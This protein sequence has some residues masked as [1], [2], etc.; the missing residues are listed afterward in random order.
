MSWKQF[1]VL[2]PYETAVVERLGRY[3]PGLK[4]NNFWKIPFLDRVITFDMR[5]QRI[6]VGF[7]GN[8]GMNKESYKNWLEKAILTS[9]MERYGESSGKSKF[10]AIRNEAL[11][12]AHSVVRNQIVVDRQLFDRVME[13][14]G[15]KI[16]RSQ[17]PQI[18]DAIDKIAIYSRGRNPIAMKIAALS[19]SELQDLKELIYA[20]TDLDTSVTSGETVLMELTAAELKAKIDTMTINT[21]NRIAYIQFLEDEYLKVM[22]EASDLKFRRVGSLFT[23]DRILINIGAT[24]LFRIEDPFRTIELIGVHDYKRT[25]IG[26]LVSSL[27]A[28][29]A[30]LTLK[31]MFEER[32]KL[33][34]LLR[35]ELD[36]V[37]VKWGIDVLSVSIEEIF[38]D[39]IKL[40]SILDDIRQEQL[41]GQTQMKRAQAELNTKRVE[42]DTKFE[43]E[44][45][46]KEAEV[47]GMIASA[48]RKLE[49]KKIEIE[50]QLTN[51]ENRF[52][53]EKTSI[54]ARKN[55]V[56][57]QIEGLIRLKNSINDDV[58]KY[59][60]MEKLPRIINDVIT[61]SK[62]IVASPG[63]DHNSIAEFLLGKTIW[64][65]L[66]DITSKSKNRK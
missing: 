65:A 18:K 61:S 34:D 60:L 6:S 46:L 63:D 59:N 57:S 1:V 3:L 19:S 52:I 66:E 15:G 51:L 35:T 38:L 42:L 32:S 4:A 20:T 24:V 26:K 58:I 17:I 27:R 30:K 23:K 37:A 44:R 49:Q 25:L 56:I 11:S 55:V 41:N 48:R 47:E 33:N 10:N 64:K 39:D 5:Q 54:E 62:M 28:A 40:Q 12:R 53:R 14:I 45:T 43:N 22:S 2:K 29:I 36:D 50:A 7:W 31:E 21:I 13:Q 8:R 16:E 9:L